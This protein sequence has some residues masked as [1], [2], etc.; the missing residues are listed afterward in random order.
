MTLTN[1]KSGFTLL[2]A[3]IFLMACTSNNVV[4]A[5][6]AV[7]AAAEVALPL[8]PNIPP[9][10]RT[11]AETYLQDASAGVSCASTELLTADA[12]VV[13]AAK[14][15]SCF[16]S[17]NYAGL[18]PVAQTIVV[19]VNAAIQAFLSNYAISPSSKALKMLGGVPGNAAAVSELKALNT[20]VLLVRH[21]LAKH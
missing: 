4:T 11:L 6:E 3:A 18:P 21:N 15:A 13:K 2:L 16:A 8:I 10:D 20:R 5:L 17:L 7:I 19:A 9:A 1:C 12:P 14:L